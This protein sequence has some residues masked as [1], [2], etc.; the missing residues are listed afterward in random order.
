MSAPAA[1]P[2]TTTDVCATLQTRMGTDWTGHVVND[3]RKLDGLQ[4]LHS[5]DSDYESEH[6]RVMQDRFMPAKMMLQDQLRALR[7]DV[8]AAQDWPQP[9]R[10][11]QTDFFDSALIQAKLGHQAP[12]EDLTRS[13]QQLASTL[14]Q[15]YPQFAVAQ[16]LALRYTSTPC[17]CP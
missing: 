3:A 7:F 10:Y 9:V 8:A 12:S 17:P 2:S 16:V 4:T 5:S 13:L 11:P 14:V 6:T 1:G 15:Q